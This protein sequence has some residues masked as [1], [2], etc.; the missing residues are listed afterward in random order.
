MSKII[1]IVLSF[2]L[3]GCG[4]SSVLQKYDN[5]R[6]SYY[7][8]YTAL[9]CSFSDPEGLNKQECGKG[10]SFSQLA[11]NERALSNCKYIDCVVVKE[12]DRWVFT[13]EQHQ[14]QTQIKNM[15]S[16]IKQ[17]EY[18]GFKRNTEKIGEC[19]L[20]ISQTEKKIVDVQVNNK[21]SSSD[22][23]A[24]LII[25]QESLKLLQPPANPRRNVQCTYNTVGGILGVN[26]F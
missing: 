10:H 17:C 8:G 19:V 6:G 1:L 15:D 21:N 22:T 25:L 11:A 26:C 18:I 14:I 13:K 23:L 20:K 9:A 12:R 5:Y 16:Y 2:F 4:S 24:N 7:K 3:V